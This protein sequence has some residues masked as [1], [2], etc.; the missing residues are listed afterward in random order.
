M[1]GHRGRPAATPWLGAQG[2]GVGSDVSGSPATDDQR[3]TA[4]RLIA[5]GGT[6][7]GTARAI[8]VGT[9]TVQRWRN[10]DPA[11]QAL[12]TRFERESERRE[13]D[14]AVK[15]A[16]RAGVP[17]PTPPG[18]LREQREIIFGPQPAQAAR[19]PAPATDA[20]VVA[21]IL[22]QRPANEHDFLDLQDARWNIASPRARARF[23]GRLAAPRLRPFTTPSTA[24]QRG[25]FDS[26]GRPDARDPFANMYDR[27]GRD[28]GGT[29]QL[30]EVWTLT[31]A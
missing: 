22:D 10:G 7:A 6:T 14:A 11:F 1:P 17:R 24:E 30:R 31:D 12:V 13:H 16:D 25:F 21:W 23:E 29:Y 19:R 9:R 2:T 27:A 28:A 4:A 15:R 26:R 3:A 18:A 5:E 8:G 20:D